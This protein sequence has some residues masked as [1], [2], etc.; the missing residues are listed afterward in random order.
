MNE[1][2]LKQTNIRTMKRNRTYWQSQ[3]SPHI[4]SLTFIYCSRPIE[5]DSNRNKIE[6][7]ILVKM[8]VLGPPELK[9]SS[10]Q[11]VCRKSR[12]LLHLL[13]P[14]SLQ[15]YQLGQKYQ[16]KQM[17]ERG[18]LKYFENRP[19]FCPKT[20]FFFYNKRFQRF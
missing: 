3:F 10:L 7:E 9:T 8:S 15:K 12:K 14:N 17:H 18:C 13:P 2:T 20:R 16:P 19:P 6:I 1:N 4:Y 11:N 5:K